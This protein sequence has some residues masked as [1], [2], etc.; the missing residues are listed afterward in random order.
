[1]SIIKLLWCK[2]VGHTSETLYSKEC[3]GSMESY[4]I[5]N[6][7][8]YEINHTTFYDCADFTP[9]DL[10]NVVNTNQNKDEDE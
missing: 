6:R 1:M 7:C 10:I 3:D 4:E 8:G 5:C 2:I 9:D